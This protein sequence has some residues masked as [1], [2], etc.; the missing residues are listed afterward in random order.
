MIANVGDYVVA[1]YGLKDVVV[2][3]KTK[4]TAAYETAQVVVDEP[5]E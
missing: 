3:F 1:V 4:L 2:E 5:I